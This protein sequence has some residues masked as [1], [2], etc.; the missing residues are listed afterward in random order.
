MKL[1]LFSIGQN[2]DRENSA[3]G[4]LPRSPGQ[5]E[6][7]GESAPSAIEAA[8][9]KEGRRDE[10]SPGSLQTPTLGRSSGRALA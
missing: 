2:D 1:L 5:A 4:T 3:E 9:A 10:E 8:S 6:T 7:G